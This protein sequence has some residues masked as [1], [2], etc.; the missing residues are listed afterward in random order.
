MNISS[1]D[2]L[3]FYWL[4]CKLIVAI[5]KYMIR[6]HGTLEKFRILVSLGWYIVKRSQIEFTL[7]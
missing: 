5:L 3:I 1:N 6:F 2:I 4:L 7:S